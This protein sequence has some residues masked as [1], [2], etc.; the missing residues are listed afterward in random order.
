MK[1][2]KRFIC[3]VFCLCLTLSC[4]AC[5]QTTKT[6]ILTDADI[7]GLDGR[8]LY[9]VIYDAAYDGE[10]YT[11]LKEE[12][13]NLSKQLRETFDIRVN[14]Y[15]DESQAEPETDAFEILIGD[16]N[17]EESAKAKELLENNR[18]NHINDYIIKVMGE[19]I[20]IYALNTDTLTAAVRYFTTTYCV[21]YDTFGKISAEFEYMH[22]QEYDLSDATVAGISL[23]DYVIVTPSSM[24]LLWSELPRQFADSVKENAGIE[25]KIV[26]ENTAVTDYEIVI[27]DTNRDTGVKVSGND[28]VIQMSG[29]KLV[30]AG[31]N[32]VALTAAMNELIAFEQACIEKKEP[33]NISADFKKQGTANKNKTDYYLAWSDEF[34]GK[35]LDRTIWRDF[36]GNDGKA[37]P[38]WDSS[39]MGGKTFKADARDCYVQNGSLY[40]PG[41][42][43]SRTDFQQSQPTTQNTLS[44]RYGIIEFRCIFPEEPMTTAI[45]GDNQYISSSGAH[46]HLLTS[47]KFIE[48][49]LVETLGSATKFHT[50]IHKDFNDEDLKGSA[51]AGHI[52]LD[53]VRYPDR[54][55][56]VDGVDTK[57]FSDGYHL[58]SLRWTPDEMTFAFDGEVYFELDLQTLHYGNDF[59]RQAVPWMIGIAYGAVNYGPASIEDNAPKLGNIVVDYMRIYQSDMYDN[60]LHITPELGGYT[61]QLTKEAQDAN[62]NWGW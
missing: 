15:T 23:K 6:Q 54:T 55:Y 53:N 51:T 32:D 49:D 16:T 48:I 9:D 43:L 39:C 2:L 35:Q 26:K 45:W 41:K 30:V 42:R 56:E 44:S 29:R 38:G 40:I 57:S 22:L 24:S 3:I 18:I 34:S 33:L 62:T 59:T 20:V 10:E 7:V 25:L 8:F 60:I 28:W 17:R 1:S 12:V 5:F 52:M 37:G 14:R 61:P 36:N 58:Y 27:G 50:N 46:K 21:G 13:V 31:G 4:T 19:K 11:A 47:S